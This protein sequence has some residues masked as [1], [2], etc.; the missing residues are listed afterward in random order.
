ML[1]RLLALI[2]LVLVGSLALAGCA[3]DLS[4]TKTLKGE[5]AK[6]ALEKVVTDSAAEFEKSGGTEQIT[7]GQ[8][9]YGLVF[10]PAVTT[11][12]K[13]VAVFDAGS[14]GPSQFTE[15][16]TIF[17][18]A[19]KK[20]ISSELFTNATYDYK[21]S[22]FTVTGTKA[23]LTVQIFENRVNGTLLRSAVAGGP[24]QATINNYGVNEI[25]KE[26][27]ST[28]TPAPAATK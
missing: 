4:S 14:G 27:L 9:Q 13:Q 10:D 21:N 6:I 28:A 23:I 17:L 18:L 7:L 24:T 12:A 11:A 8:K 5:A 20:L 19:L 25:A 1:K 3:T 15:K 26:K 22:G 16:S 2:A